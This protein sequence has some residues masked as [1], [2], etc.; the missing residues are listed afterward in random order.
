[1]KILAILVAYAFF[2]WLYWKAD[3]GNDPNWPGPGGP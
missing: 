3:C 1:M 2:G